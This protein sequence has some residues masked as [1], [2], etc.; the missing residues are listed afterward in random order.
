V[1]ILKETHIDF[2][3]FRYIAY[4]I[5]A[6]VILAGLVSLIVKGGPNW[7]VDF[8]GGIVLQAKFDR[9]VTTDEVRSVIE[10]AGIS[11]VSVQ[12][13]QTKDEVIVSTPEV[14]QIKGKETSDIMKESLIKNN[15]WTIDE[16]AINVDKV[17][18]SVGKDLIASAT[19]SVL[20]GLLLILVYVAIRFE[21]RFGL[22]GIVALFHDVFVTLGIFSLLN[23]PVDLTA[24]AAFLTI[25][26]FSINDTIVIFDRVR[27][28]MKLMKGKTFDEILNLS[29]NQTLS[30]TIITTGT[31][32]LTVLAILIIARVGSLH[33]LS[34]ALFIGF[35]SGVYSTLYIASPIA[36]AWHFSIIP[37]KLKKAES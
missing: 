36:R 11:D 2:I 24:I 18:P 31:A 30:R 34:L 4:T 6:V 7:G 10:S 22:G 9:A 16:K 5:S 20:L 15:T 12:H 29:I 35:I 25:I 21:F 27:E 3:G 17:S 33:I 1:Q 37:K 32:L 23:E 8:K 26:G 28:N 19:K 14:Q 13:G